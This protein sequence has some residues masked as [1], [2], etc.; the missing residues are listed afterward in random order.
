MEYYILA[1]KNKDKFI[2]LDEN[3]NY[4]VT[5][6][7]NKATR[8]EKDEIYELKESFLEMISELWQDIDSQKEKVKLLS[9]FIV[10][11]RLY[12]VTTIIEGVKNNV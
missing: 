6:D 4:Y 12:K 9:S 2:A 7:I 8:W 10:S 3:K 11:S 5:Y 1:N